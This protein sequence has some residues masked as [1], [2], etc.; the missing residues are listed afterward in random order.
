[1]ITLLGNGFI[2]KLPTETVFDSAYKFQLQVTCKILES[3]AYML[4]SV[5][6]SL[7]ATVS[8][9]LGSLTVRQLSL[10]ASF[11]DLDSSNSSKSVIVE[12]ILT[13]GELPVKISATLTNSTELLFKFIEATPPTFAVALFV[14]DGLESN[15][16]LQAPDVTAASGFG[17][18]K[19]NPAFNIEVVF[20]KA[21]GGGWKPSSL[22]LALS[23]TTKW[24]LIN[25]LLWIVDMSFRLILKD[26]S[27][28][29]PTLGVQLAANFAWKNRKPPPDT[30]S[31]PTTLTA[32]R[33]DLNILLKTNECTLPDF[34]YITTGGLWDPPDA[35]DFPLV[36][37]QSLQLVLSWDDKTATIVILWNDW[38]VVRTLPKIASIQKPTLQAGLYNE[39]S[40]L[41]AK[42]E[43]KGMIV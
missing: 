23:S 1:M 17:N 34:L 5:E 25:E 6:L 27:S 16:R 9:Q 13:L 31:L 24:T 35:L 4:K 33:K 21:S 32:T 42:G 15:G 3:G 36:T 40:G 37:P 38:S 26:I 20:L 10:K 39:D 30:K 8:W 12:G 29:N 43:I 41:S 11:T 7:N 28:D 2:D 22:T 19:T 18:Y 14:P